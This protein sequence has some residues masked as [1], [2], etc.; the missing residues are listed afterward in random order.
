MIEPIAFQRLQTLGLCCLGPNH[1]EGAQP[2][3][4]VENCIKDLLSIA[5]PSRTRLSFPHRKF[6]PLGSLHKPLI[7]IHSR[8]AAAAK[9]LQSCVTLCNP[10]D[11]SPRGSSVPG[12]FQAKKTGVGCHFLLQYR[13]VKSES[14]VVQLCPTLKRPLGL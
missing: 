6:L 8:A 11:G 14:E 3:A 7:P 5:L 12:I 13:K 1:R 2:H 10:I 9:S 4:P